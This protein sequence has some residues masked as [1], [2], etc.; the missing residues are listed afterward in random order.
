MDAL[1]QPLE[2]GTL[3]IH[4]S[5]ATARYPARFQLVLAANPCPCGRASGH[6]R[7]CTCTPM[8]QRRYLRRLSGPLLDRV[9]LQITVRPVTRS[10]IRRVGSG[11]SSAVVAARVAA[12]RGAQRERLAAVGWRCNAEVPGAELTTGA[13]RLAGSTT[14]DLDRAMERGTLTVRGYH[15]VLRV[16]WT[17]ADLSGRPAPGRDEVALAVEL[18]HSG[19]VAA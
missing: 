9:D 10:A 7:D 15:R 13:L 3:T 6:G 16:A 12:A 14:Q 19:P 2:D 18:R 17:L 1:R 8:A 4:R 5:K 11:E